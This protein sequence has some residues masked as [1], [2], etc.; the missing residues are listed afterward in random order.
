MRRTVLLL[1]AV[2]LYAGYVFAFYQWILSGHS[3]GD[4]WQAASSDW[5]LA[6][7]LFDLSL[8]GLLC[9]IWLY[10]D[11]NRGD[12]STS[13]K[14]LIL[15]AALIIGVVVLLLY[16]AFRKTDDRT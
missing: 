5:F 14:I 13:R 6:V 9:L 10:R 11:M 8:F 4:V 7:T 16:L 3:F 15:T 12:F 2:S 1:L